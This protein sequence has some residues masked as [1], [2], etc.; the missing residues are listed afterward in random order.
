MPE[1]LKASPF[2]TLPENNDFVIHGPGLI[3]DQ[4]DLI[5]LP[6]NSLAQHCHSIATTLQ[7][8]QDLLNVTGSDLAREKCSFGALTYD[9]TPTRYG[10]ASVSLFSGADNPGEIQLQPFIQSRPLTTLRRLVP[11]TVE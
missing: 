9:F 2:P 3:D 7:K 1:N 8:W 6:S 10:D 4:I 11:D 5:S